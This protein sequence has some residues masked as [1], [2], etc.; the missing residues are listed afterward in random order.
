MTRIRYDRDPLRARG[1]AMEKPK[2]IKGYIA[3][4]DTLLT[5]DHQTTPWH[6]IDRAPA[7][8][9]QRG[10]H[11]VLM[12]SMLRGGNP[13]AWMVGV[14]TPRPSAFTG[15]TYATL[16][17]AQ[18]AFRKATKTAGRSAPKLHGGRVIR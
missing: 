1:V 18:I 2:A 10:S 7:L 4:N 16:K 14:E 11:T 15:R 5:L 17:L 8:H 13:V 6:V 3:Y 12:L 9:S